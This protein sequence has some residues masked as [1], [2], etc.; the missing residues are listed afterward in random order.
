MMA[1]YGLVPSDIAVALAEQNLEAAPD[2]GGYN[3][4][5][6]NMSRNTKDV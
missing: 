1:S 3:Q 5:S 4:F 6:S 2:N